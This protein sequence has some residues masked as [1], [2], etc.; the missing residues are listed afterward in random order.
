MLAR[1]NSLGLRGVEGFPVVVEL[2]LAGGLPAFA[3][4]GLPDNAV[5][6]ARERVSAAVRNSGFK[7]PSRRRSGVFGKKLN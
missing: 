4:V 2:D 6:E 1:V 7:F 3:T 5:K